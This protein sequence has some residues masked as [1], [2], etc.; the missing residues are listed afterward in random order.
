MTSTT[1]L[2][3][4][5]CGGPQETRERIGKAEAKVSSWTTEFGCRSGVYAMDL[6][7]SSQ[8]LDYEEG[9]EQRTRRERER[10]R[11]YDRL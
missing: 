11:E 6:S 7:C 10:E 2:Q 3:Y 4:L 1:K 8:D 9:Y 5:L